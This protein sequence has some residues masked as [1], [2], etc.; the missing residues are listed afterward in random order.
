MSYIYLHGFASSPRSYKAQDLARR[1]AQLN[2]P[3]IIPDLNQ[4]DFAHLT[5]TRQLRQVE[6]LL[7]VDAEP[8]TIIGSSFGGLTAAWLAETHR[9]IDR[10]VLLAP[11]F[12]F[13]NHWSQRLGAA[14]MQQWQSTGSLP[15][16]HYTEQRQLPLDYGFITDAAQYNLAKIQ[17]PVPTLIL[18]GLHDE[19][20]P[21][22]S[23]QEFA[24][25]RPWVSLVEL[26]SDH[27]LANASDP[28]WQAIQSFCLSPTPLPLAP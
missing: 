26:N 15:V 13:L 22:A 10:L 9:Q 28:I 2:L 16:F 21:I 24:Q 27:A 4:G 12:G 23:S 11:A 14:Q 18:H 1:F 5:L 25:T 8:V 19:V 7:N 6:A 20:I 17:R 3:L